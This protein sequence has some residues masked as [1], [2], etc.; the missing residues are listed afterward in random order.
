MIENLSE[1]KNKDSKPKVIAVV[2]AT[3]SGKT[4]YSIE[5]AKQINGEIISA[6]S[7]LVYRGFNIAC[8]KPTKQEQCGISH[9]MIDIVSP[10]VDYTAGLYAREARKLIYDITNRGKV[11]IVVGGTGLY[12]RLLL[13]N[14]EPPKVKPDYELR[15]KLKTLTT[16]DLYETLL[17]LDAD[18]ASTIEQNDRKKLIRAIEIVKIGGK[19][20]SQI[21]GISEQSEFDVEWI[22]LNFPRE[23]LYDR[24]NKRVDIMMEQGMLDET[25]ALLDKYGRIPNLVATI[26]YREIIRY[27]D[28]I[29]SLN[30]AL[31]LLKQNS[32]KY[33]KRQ[34]TWFRKNQN[35]RWNC[36][37]EPVKK[38]K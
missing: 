5:L 4:S 21:R 20:L 32:R 15:D 9:Y 28:G 24:I 6:D 14:Y 25:K 29:S 35:I 37:P 12:F 16:E 2:G 8:A 30:E 13:E 11:P 36:Y 34:L 33:A 17:T 7:R 31:E 19:P 23:D 10:E 26:G 27:L 38:K 3:A 22:G 18:G 1:Q